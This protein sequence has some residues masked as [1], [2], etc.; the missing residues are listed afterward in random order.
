MKKI[1]F[2]MLLFFVVAISCTK[3]ENLPEEAT[4]KTLGIERVGFTSAVCKL[5]SENTDTTIVETGVCWSNSGLPTISENFSNL[6]F[7]YSDIKIYRTL[8][9]NLADNT[10]FYARAYVK[11]SKGIISYGDT[12]KFTTLK[13]NPVTVLFQY[14][15]ENSAWSDVHEGF[16]ID[17]EGIIR[18]YDMWFWDRNIYSDPM[19]DPGEYIPKDV[20]Y[21]TKEDL[22]FN[23]Y[24]TDT[25]Y[26]QVN[27]DTL[28]KMNNLV[29]ALVNSTSTEDPGGG[30]DGGF[31]SFFAYYWDAENN[32]YQR[33]VLEVSRDAC[34]KNKENGAIVLSD[35][36]FDI[37]KQ[38]ILNLPEN[39]PNTALCFS[40]S[41]HCEE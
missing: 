31:M 26:G 27:I 33:I 15:Y 10:T 20:A 7:Y 25:C 28:N 12:I 32:R 6:S 24:L 22:E 38:K 19:K 40:C 39:Y 34:R 30:D 18:G 29:P 21:Y 3:E 13:K 37:M 2:S 23:Y 5:Y 4:V 8:M 9:Y 11:N 14:N 17:S 1:A 41:Y 16:Y 35:W 36:L